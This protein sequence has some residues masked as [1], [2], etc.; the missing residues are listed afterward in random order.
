M[1]GIEALWSIA[2]VGEGWSH[3]PDLV[4]PAW[5][6][7]CVRGGP[8]GP[9]LPQNKGNGSNVLGFL[10]DFSVF[11]GISLAA[12]KLTYRERNNGIKEVT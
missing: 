4:F 6:G 9:Y 3:W 12:K 5:K 1:T 7:I 8:G 2:W 10:G 11:T